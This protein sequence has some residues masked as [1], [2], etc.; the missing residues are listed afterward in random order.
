MQKAEKDF[1]LKL[2]VLSQNIKRAVDVHEHLA[3]SIR[4]PAELMMGS[5]DGI[6]VRALSLG[7]RS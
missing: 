5:F 2:L 1:A 4:R 3:Q 7:I 6:K